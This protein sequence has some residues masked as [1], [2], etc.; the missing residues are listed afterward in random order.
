MILLCVVGFHGFSQEVRPKD[1]VVLVV[2]DPNHPWAAAQIGAVLAD[3]VAY[4]EGSLLQA[5]TLAKSGEAKGVIE[6]KLD[7]DAAFETGR[8]VCYA[9]NGKKLWE[10]KIFVNFGG[11]AEAIARKFADKLEVKVK[12]KHCPQ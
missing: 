2:P 9:P 10:E 6:I 12:G 3:E 5:L 7:T 1:D 4:H 11:G 8:V